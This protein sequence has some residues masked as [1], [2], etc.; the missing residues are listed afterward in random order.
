MDRR[1][2]LIQ[3]FGSQLD[4]QTTISYSYTDSPLRLL[5]YDVYYF[6][7]YA[8]ALP[9]I[10]WP[11]R[12]TEPGPLSELSFNFPNV[13]CILVHVVLC[14]LQ[15]G[16]I[17]LLPL[18]F[19]LPVWTAAAGVAVFLL[20]NSALC[21]LL[22]GSPWTVTYQ[23]DPR[24]APDLPEHA[25]EQ[26]VFLNGVAVGRHWLQSN[27]DRL[28]IT[29]KRPVLGIHNRTSG[30]PFDIL[31]CLIQRN[32][33]YATNDVRAC[34]KIIKEKLYN[35]AFSKVIFILHSQGG[36]EGGMV[37]DWLLQE[38]PQDQLAKLE[39]YTFGNAANHFNN[40]HRHLTSQA[41]ALKR[42]L[43]AFLDA[44]RAATAIGDSIGGSYSGTGL[45]AGTGTVRAQDA[46]ARSKGTEASAKTA[47]NGASNPGTLASLGAESSASSPSA[48]SDRAV[49]H[50][51]H[52]AHTT[53]FV[54]RWGVL[55]FATSAVASHTVSRFMGRVFART[56]PQGG[57][58]LNQHYLAGMFPLE[59]HPKTSEFVG[60]ADTGNVFMESEIAIG[61]LGDGAKDE[62]EAM[63]VSWLGGGWDVEE[64]ER[65]VEI[66]D[67]SSPVV[68][69]GR[70][71]KRGGA[72]GAPKTTVKVKELSRLW[73]YRNGRSPTE[74]PPL[75][76]RGVD[77]VL[78][79][80][81]M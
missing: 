7:S 36:I 20:S 63:E 77:G 78:R 51:E 49:G 13:F 69:Q 9:Y 73:K 72:S 32:F 81:T 33:G 76:A 8:W 16:F 40:P 30:I 35:P 19:L 58:Q 18:A 42:P 54:A 60:C 10:L 74:K 11:V 2:G 5:A 4:R 26:W 43:A 15:V 21:I 62:R 68:D 37:L 53:D 6:C 22:N 75:L 31:E 1:D 44:T 14:V 57:H 48:V 71:R 79:G 3:F 67:G 46:I 24:L 50:I 55:H 52:Y 61:T 70:D 25:H 12:P 47:T 27:L 23:S 34:Y 17:L 80:A 65:L 59:R 56:S 45:P 66:H 64:A 29:F 39:I 28:A 38:L 41:E